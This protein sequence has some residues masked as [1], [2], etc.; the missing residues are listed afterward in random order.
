MTTY[1]FTTQLTQG[2]RHEDAIDVFFNLWYDITTA[3]PAQQRQGIDRLWKRLDGVGRAVTVEYKADSLAG[4]TGNA[5]IETV[6][7]DTTNKP[8][9]ALSS[10]AQLLIYLVT[11]PQTIYMIWMKRLRQHLPRWQQQ[12]PL[13]WVDNRTYHTGGHLVPLHELETIAARII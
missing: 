11:D 2:H 7:V 8:G 10:Q 4:R 3:T 13:R 12:Y 6:S 1:D 5:F 9:W